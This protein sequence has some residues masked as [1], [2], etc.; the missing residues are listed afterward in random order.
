VRGI[1][2]LHRAVDEAVRRQLEPHWHSAG[3]RARQMVKVRVGVGVWVRNRVRV[4]Q[5]ARAA[6]G[7]G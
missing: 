4:S 1:G 6:D 5:V 7:Q 3:W 2:L